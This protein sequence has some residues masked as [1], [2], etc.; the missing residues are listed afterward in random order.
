MKPFNTNILRMNETT[1]HFD[2]ADLSESLTFEDGYLVGTI[3]N[4]L[5]HNHDW[6]LNAEKRK[7]AIVAAAAVR[8]ILNHF[9]QTPEMFAIKSQSRK[10]MRVKKPI[11]HILYFGGP[12]SYEEITRILG[13]KNRNSCYLAHNTYRKEIEVSGQFKEDYKA[14]CELPEVINL[15]WNRY[16]SKEFMKHREGIQLKDNTKV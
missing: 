8:A 7:Y 11:V 2:F 3:V 15:N 9:D 6:L 16:S 14:I 1:H 5:N 10:F 13:W 4:S 12:Y